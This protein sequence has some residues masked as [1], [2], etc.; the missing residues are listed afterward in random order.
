MDKFC[1]FCGESPEDKNREHVLPTWLIEMTG[2]PKRMATFGVDPYKRPLASR[3]FAFNSLVFPAC[4]GCNSRFGKLEATVKPIVARLLANGSVSSA[5]LI[6][7]LDWLDKVRVGLWLGYLYLDKNPLGIT[8]T[9]H[10]DSRIGRLDRM[11]AIFKIEGVREGLTFIGPQF[12]MYQLSPTCFAVRV[13]EMCLVN[14]SGVS[15]CSQRLGFPY[16]EPVRINE[17]HR[18]EVSLH[19]GSERIMNPVE[20]RPPLPNA[21]TLYQPIFRGILESEEPERFVT[22]EW[23]KQHTAETGIGH[24]KLFVQKPKSIEI[25]P[26]KDS[27]DWIPLGAWPKAEITTQLPDYVHERIRRDFE[28]AIPLACSK[29]DRKD[30]RKHALLTRMVDRAM[31]L[32]AKV[33]NGTK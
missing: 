33:A 11:V 2:D 1:V 20:R 7:L 29:E 21:V 27:S 32:K 9:F 8:P 25:Y 17:D 16:M 22:G 15:L 24:G 4:A 23:V 19:I 3:E 26:D 12:R 13:N 18:L 30:M 5:E 14:A 6:Q 31:L 10:I 28:N